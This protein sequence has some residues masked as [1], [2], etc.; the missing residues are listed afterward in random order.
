MTKRVFAFIMLFLIFALVVP[1]ASAQSLISGDVTGTVT[2]P[3]GAVIPN[4]NVTLKSVDRGETLNATTNEAGNYRFSL[5]K[6]GR[7]NVTVSHSGFQ[8]AESVVQV[9]VGQATSANL[10]LTMGQAT[11]L[12]EVSGAAPLIN[13]ENANV[14]TSFDER[15]LSMVPNPGG[16]LTNIA[17]TAPGV[18]MNTSGGY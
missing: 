9:A 12:V 5:L 18:T 15:S 4:A 1:A 14:S 8:K 17:Q 10:T 7:Y 16:D 3:T 13:V 6:P 2:D 11:E